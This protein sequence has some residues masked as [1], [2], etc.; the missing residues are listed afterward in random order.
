MTDR[1]DDPSPGGVAPAGEVGATI[2]GLRSRAPR[3]RLAALGLVA[4]VIAVMV[5][6]ALLAPDPNVVARV[7]P[8]GR[9]CVQVDGRVWQSEAPVLPAATEPTA[10]EGRWRVTG[11]DTA[12]LTTATGTVIVLRLEHDPRVSVLCE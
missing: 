8:A 12:E 9:V 2:H 1:P 6:V 7:S 3:L 5:G 4:L 10:V 11:A